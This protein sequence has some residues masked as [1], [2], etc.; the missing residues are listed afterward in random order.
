MTT[1]VKE[2]TLHWDSFIERGVPEY[3][4]GMDREA[5]IDEL[6]RHIAQYRQENWRQIRHHLAVEYKLLVPEDL[7]PHWTEPGNA[8]YWEQ[9]ATWSRKD[10]QPKRGGEWEEK[11][12]DWVPTGPFP[13]NN[14]SQIAQR[15]EKGLRL[16]PP[17]MGLSVETLETDLPPETPSAEPEKNFRFHCA[18]HRYGEFH[19]ETWKQY[20][21]H[22]KYH[23]EPLE[24]KF[25]GGMHKRIR[26][27]EFYC[28]LHNLGTQDERSMQQHIRHAHT[29]RNRVV[30]ANLESM[31]V[32]SNRGDTR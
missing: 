16:R 30:Q 14:A 27:F 5:R 12:G 31:R 9:Q 29:Q 7:E 25:P 28:G 32:I 10:E 15:L 23:A 22:C 20:R 6:R 3:L 18:R 1:A 21:H 24:H 26:K 17:G 2:K 11:V 8:V 13:A 19:F 4:N